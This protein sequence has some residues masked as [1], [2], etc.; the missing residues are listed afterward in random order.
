[1]GFSLAE[2]KALMASR[3]VSHATWRDLVRRKV[4]ELDGQIAKARV[5]RVA[6]DHAL[7]CLQ[8][9]LLECPNFWVSSRRA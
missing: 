8:K 1:M 4:A 7:C 5:A 2:T 3:E 6:L 9:D